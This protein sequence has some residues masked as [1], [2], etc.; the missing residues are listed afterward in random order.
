MELKL[1]VPN[2]LQAF[3]LIEVITYLDDAERHGFGC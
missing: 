3:L 2:V 1:N